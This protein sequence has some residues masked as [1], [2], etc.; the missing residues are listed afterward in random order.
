MFIDC[1]LLTSPVI[2]P[3]FHR[4]SPVNPLF[5]VLNGI[6]TTCAIDALALSIVPR[7]HSLS[8]YPHRLTSV[9]IL[10]VCQVLFHLTHP[11]HVPHVS[12]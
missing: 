10:T 7:S 1:S 8:H 5:L 4:H 3:S 9:V 12:R 6:S 2:P 11:I